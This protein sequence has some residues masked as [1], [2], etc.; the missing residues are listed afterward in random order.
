MVQRARSPSPAWV[1]SPNK[2]ASPADNCNNSW[3]VLSAE[4]NG[5]KYGEYPHVK[6]DKYLVP[7][8]TA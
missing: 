8:N 1:I 5:W 3:T 2:C 6:Y 4:T 7:I